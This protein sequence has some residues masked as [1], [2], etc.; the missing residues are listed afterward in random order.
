[1]PSKRHTKKDKK[2]QK[3]KKQKNTTFKKKSLV[4]GRKSLDEALGEKLTPE[5]IQNLVETPNKLHSIQIEYCSDNNFVV[6][7]NN[8]FD[9]PF[10]F[11]GFAPE[12]TN[13]EFK[14]MDDFTISDDLQAGKQL[15]IVM[16]ASEEGP[17]MYGTR[18]QEITTGPRGQKETY[19]QLSCAPDKLPVIYSVPEI[20]TPDNIASEV[21]LTPV[22]DEQ[23]GEEE[24]I[25]DDIFRDSLPYDELTTPDDLTEQASINMGDLQV[26]DLEDVTDIAQSNVTE[27]TDVSKELKQTIKDKELEG[28]SEKPELKNFKDDLD[29]L[30]KKTPKSS[31]QSREEGDIDTISPKIDLKELAREQ[32]E[33]KRKQQEE[34]DRLAHEARLKAEEEAKTKQE[35]EEIDED[36]DDESEMLFEEISDS[37]AEEEEMRENQ[38][39]QFERYI[40]EIV[41]IKSILDATILAV[42]TSKYMYRDKYSSSLEKLFSK[43]KAFI[44][45]FIDEMDDFVDIDDITKD[46]IVNVLTKN[47]DLLKSKEKPT[48]VKFFPQKLSYS[49]RVMEALRI[50]FT[51]LSQKKDALEAKNNLFKMLKPFS[52]GK[53][54]RKNRRKTQQRK[55]KKRT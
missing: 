7:T 51:E 53:K 49:S 25:M 38:Y 39:Q 12:E 36:I 46:K 30:K 22:T 28:V 1:M 20:T 54:T 3:G 5:F 8:L 42:E 26:E 6:N 47:L 16:Y 23:L 10:D 27:P 15:E 55:T 50:F 11:Q 34:I 32:K 43:Y 2:Q 19:H 14:N 31:L 40:N 45:N 24:E 33:A 52:G 13:I 4:G 29:L 21:D 41:I 9:I 48:T 37:E 44:N 35:E 18:I 17:L